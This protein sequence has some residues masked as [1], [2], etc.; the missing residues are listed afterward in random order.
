MCG[1]AGFVRL[2]GGPAERSVI[3]RM[4]D[5][6]RHRGPDGSGHFIDG[7]LALGHRRLSILDLSEHGAQPMHN[8]G[9]TQVLTFNG[10]IY[11]YLEIREQL[12]AKGYIFRTETDSEV[13]LAA[14]D[15]WGDECVSRFNGMWAFAIFDRARQRLFLSRDRFGVKPLYYSEGRNAF[16]FGSEIRQLLPFGEGVSA[17]MDVIRTFLVTSFSD[18][19]DR[20]FFRGIRCLPGGH[21]ATF[22]LTHNR[23]TIQRYYE[24]SPREDVGSLS[25]SD[26]AEEFSALFEDAVRLRLRSDVKVGTCLSGGLDSSSVAAT[27]SE[28]YRREADGRFGAITAVSEQDSNNEA[29]FAEMVVKSSDLDWHCTKPSYQDFVSSLPHVV[30]AQEEPFGGPSLTMQYFVMKAARDNGIVVLLD[31]QGGD[32]TLLGYEKYYAAYIASAF[33]R[34]G[35]GATV[36]ALRASARNNAKM[37]PVNMA[38]YLV[39]AL[40]APARYAFY[41]RRH[42]HFDRHAPLPAPLSAFAKSCFDSFRL[43]KLEIEST[44]LPVL[45]RYEDKNSMAHSVEARLPF[46][47]YRL[48]E[49][50]LSLPDRYKIRDG[51]SKWILRKTMTGRLPEAVA[52][53][54]NKF[55]FEAPED[56]WLT[57]HAAEMQRTVLTSPLLGEMASANAFSKAMQR[58]DKRS[59]WRLYS[60]ALWER[61]FKV[62]S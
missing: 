20:T 10:E 21:S 54:K 26:A 30:R 11:N 1:I 25:I 8:A 61:E 58:L 7:S 13:I 34:D 33:R 3:E 53:R 12:R 48:L 23:F 49:L 47:D 27:A 14:Y 52:W 15:C 31:G 36:A 41:K 35:I 62:A 50:S 24:V 37:H 38:K 46:L 4:T 40:V 51:W 32:E 44:N 42:R 5:A 56:I 28:L 16:A 19:D 59:R 57:K 17:D 55:G 43:Q 6:V 60:V 22:N 18:V 39:G 45:L 2:D 29:H 9:G